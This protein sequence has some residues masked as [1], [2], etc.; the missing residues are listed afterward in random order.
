[1]LAE[2]KQNSAF[3]KFSISLLL[4]TSVLLILLQ[5]SPSYADITD[6]LSIEKP[7]E[8]Q[9]P[10]FVIDPENNVIPGTEVVN[11]I[12]EETIRTVTV[13]ANVFIIIDDSTSME[14]G[15]NGGGSSKS[16]SSGSGSK[17]AIATRTLARFVSSLG[18]NVN[19]GYMGL[20]TQ[21]VFYP[22]RS[23][24]SRYGNTSWKNFLINRISTH[25]PRQSGTKL[26]ESYVFAYQHLLSAA[27]PITSPF[28]EKTYVVFVSD[29]EGYDS[30]NASINWARSVTG[31]YGC[32][33][34]SCVIELAR[35]FA[36][37]PPGQRARYQTGTARE[38]T[39]RQLHGRL[40][41]QCGLA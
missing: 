25:R 1:M 17:M 18:N 38:S 24:G 5:A 21:K 30:S 26:T 14:D 41:L 4:L 28:H 32:N 7:E 3:V 11:T 34:S 31:S 23:L 10:G 27:S 8:C 33:E 36:P 22:S 2:S 6:V 39:C 19:V 40:G 12:I 20:R 9:D 13:P 29:G 15:L 35:L 16:S 37:A